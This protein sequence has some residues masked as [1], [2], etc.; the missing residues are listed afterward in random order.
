VPGAQALRGGW[1]ALVTDTAFV[2]S[3]L[4]LG[5]CTCNKKP[6]PSTAL[7]EAFARPNL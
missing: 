6:L 7:R 2:L 4:A 1:L 3:I 5:P